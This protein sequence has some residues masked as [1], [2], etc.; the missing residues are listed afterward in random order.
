M[1]NEVILTHLREHNQGIST[2]SCGVISSV[3]QPQTQLFCPALS[4]SHTTSSE[5]TQSL[6]SISCKQQK[7]E[8]AAGMFHEASS[9]SSTLS[10][11][12]S[13]TCP[14]KMSV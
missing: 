2:F 10:E 9:E 6:C 8:Q 3:K 7:A 4:L 12:S 13:K 11:E 1:P 14:V 5:V